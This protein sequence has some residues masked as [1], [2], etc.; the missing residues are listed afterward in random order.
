MSAL[1]W[2]CED[3][4]H[5]V[6]GEHVTFQERHDERAGGCGCHVV[7][8]EDRA[9]EGWHPAETAPRDGKP[10]LFLS[11][12]FLEYSVGCW[13]GDCFAMQCAPP[14]APFDW[15]RHLEPAPKTKETS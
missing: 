4:Q 1:P 12:A 6:P 9:I 15:W 10:I 2:W 5:G 7:P 14:M 3:C 8:W 13:D 11:S